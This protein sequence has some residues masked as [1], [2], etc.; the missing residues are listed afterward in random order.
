MNIKRA[1]V[2]V[3]VLLGAA[4]GGAGYIALHSAPSGAP[5]QDGVM[6]GFQRQADPAPMPAVA[7]I[8]EAGNATD[9]SRFKGKITLVNLWATWCSPCV[10]EMPSLER[11]KTARKSDQFDVAT[12]SEDVQGAPAV[13]AFFAK[14]GLAGLPRYLDPKNAMTRAFKLNGLPTTLLLDR[15]G[16][17][18]GRFEGVADWDGPEALRLI[19]WYVAH[20]G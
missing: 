2:G 18:I 1:L 14:N 3:V 5:P 17:E 11:L 9:L 7:F 12:I 8:D 20:A 13:E 4:A 6:A 15:E 10:K 19:D 16:R